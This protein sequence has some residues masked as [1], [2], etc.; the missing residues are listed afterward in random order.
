MPDHPSFL[1]QAVSKSCLS[2]RTLSPSTTHSLTFYDLA[3]S[4]MKEKLLLGNRVPERSEPGLKRRANTHHLSQI[5]TGRVGGWMVLALTSNPALFLRLLRYDWCYIHLKE[6]EGHTPKGLA[7]FSP[8]VGDVTPLHT[9]GS[10]PCH[11]FS[12][13]RSQLSKSF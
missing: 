4:T 9:G 6:A 7:G 5:L 10:Q 3:Y 13:S 1:K 2:R 8:Q 12:L 11:T